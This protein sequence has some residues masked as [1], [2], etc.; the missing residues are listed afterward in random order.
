MHTIPGPHYAASSI[1]SI[2]TLDGCDGMET[3]IC[4]HWPGTVASSR[5]RIPRAPSSEYD[6]EDEDVAPDEWLSR[7]RADGRGEFGGLVETRWLGMVFVD[8]VDKWDSW[9]VDWYL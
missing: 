1:Y 5:E 2:P 7:G 3:P 8:A 4:L 9:L 6:A